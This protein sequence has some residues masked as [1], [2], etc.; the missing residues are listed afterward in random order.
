MT[1]TLN[2]WRR[3]SARFAAAH[4]D[5]VDLAQEVLKE[6]E[7]FAT[8]AERMRYNSAKRDCSSAPAWSK[9]AA[10]PSSAPGWSGSACSGLSVAP[11]PSSPCVAAAST[12]GS[13]TTGN[14]IGWH[15]Q[16]FFSLL[17]LTPGTQGVYFQVPLTHC[18][19]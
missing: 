4:A 15:D 8:N 12:G 17:S 2:L 14:R 3:A 16:S 7:Y 1:A 10:S 9:R 13:R 19:V 18:S 5:A 11:T 6:A